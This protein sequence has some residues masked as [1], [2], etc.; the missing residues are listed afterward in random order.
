LHLTRAENGARLGWTTWLGQ[1][2]DIGRDRTITV[3]LVSSR[4][5]P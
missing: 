2:L 3:E 4:D 1:G 5:A